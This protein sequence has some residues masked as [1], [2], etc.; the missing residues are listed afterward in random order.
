M[1]SEERI[2]PQE[3]LHLDGEIG[4]GQRG[5]SVVALDNGDRAI[6]AVLRIAKEL[7]PVGRAVEDPDFRNAFTGVEPQ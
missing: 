1:L 3:I 7:D 2:L 4:E 5:D 6:D